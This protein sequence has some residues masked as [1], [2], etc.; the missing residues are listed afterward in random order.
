[1]EERQPQPNFSVTR[2]LERLSTLTFL[3][4]RKRFLKSASGTKPPLLQVASVPG[5][6]QRRSSRTK[7]QR[8]VPLRQQKIPTALFLS[9][10]FSAWLQRTPFECFPRLYVY[11]IPSRIIIWAGAVFLVIMSRISQHYLVSFYRSTTVHSRLL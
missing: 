6:G 5:W 4:L 3:G 11:L 8:R 1:M 9:A 10:A 2:E 7:Q